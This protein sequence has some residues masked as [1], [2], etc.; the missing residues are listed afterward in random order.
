MVSSSAVFLPHSF[1]GSRPSLLCN[2]NRIRVSEKKASSSC[3]S[4]ATAISASVELPHPHTPPSLY[5]EFLQ[6]SISE[7]GKHG[8]L[9]TFPMEVIYFL[10]TLFYICICVC[11]C[12]VSVCVCICT[13]ICNVCVGIPTCWVCICIL[14]CSGMVRICILIVS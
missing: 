1:S 14:I 12:C 11:I 5:H 3:T 8:N 2:H 9:S 13:I 6:F 4:I 10:S 7:V